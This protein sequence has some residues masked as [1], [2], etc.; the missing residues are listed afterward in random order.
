MGLALAGAGTIP[1]AAAPLT[2]RSAPATDQRL[3]SEPAAPDLTV[4][5]GRHLEGPHLHSVSTS[6]TYA[7]GA[8]DPARG[9]RAGACRGASNA[10]KG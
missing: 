6:M 9:W 2:R 4:Q 3:I 1:E 10:R 5:R 7:R 8:Q